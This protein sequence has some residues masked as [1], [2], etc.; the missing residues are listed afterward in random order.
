VAQQI[1]VTVAIIGIGIFN[2]RWKIGKP[3]SKNIISQE[4]KAPANQ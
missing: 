3:K 2:H 1:P 4:N